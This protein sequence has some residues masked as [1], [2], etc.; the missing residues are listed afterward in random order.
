MTIWRCS[1][2]RSSR[3]GWCLQ[4]VE[5]R[6]PFAY[7][8]GL[9]EIG[10]SELLVTGVSIPRARRLLNAAAWHCLQNGSPTLGARLMLPGG[11]LVEF[12]ELE[13]PDVHMG[14]LLN[15]NA[16]Y[17]RVPITT[18]QMVWADGRGRFPWSRE[19]ADGRACQPVLGA[20]IRAR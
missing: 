1:G 14:M 7:T 4:Y 17:T 3:C 20:R 11:P 6:I 2:A 13:R 12:V 15:Y 16:A 8:I 5:D 18:K 10:L 9:H 19:F